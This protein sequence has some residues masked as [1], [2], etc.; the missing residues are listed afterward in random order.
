MNPDVKR[1]A[2]RERG[3]LSHAD[4]ENTG[5]YASGQ[6]VA[7]AVTHRPDLDS[8]LADI[9]WLSKVFLEQ[10]RN[11]VYNNEIPDRSERKEFKDVCETV[12]RMAKL[13]LDIEKHQA[14]QVGAMKP[15][16]IRAAITQALQQKGLGQEV[17][18]TVL[19]ALGISPT[20]SESPSPT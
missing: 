14:S 12:M 18:D 8:M 13:E 7:P 20:P 1:R 16:E 9:A 3:A 4:L 5:N 10:L 19:A 15:H 17:V 6:I 2:H 11:K